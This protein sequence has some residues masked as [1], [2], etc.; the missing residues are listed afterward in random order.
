[1]SQASDYLENALIGHL[2]RNI[3]LTA[4]TTVAVALFTSSPTDTGTAGV[5]VHTSGGYARQS[6]SFGQALTGS[7]ANNATLT[8]GPAT[9]N[10]GSITHF[11]IFDN[12]TSGS[13]NMLVWGALNSPVSISNGDSLQFASAS[14]AITIA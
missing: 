8:F 10:W 4:P 1:M 3:S 9:T 11:A 14:L 2:F 13:G 5:E 7:T 12:A 6:G